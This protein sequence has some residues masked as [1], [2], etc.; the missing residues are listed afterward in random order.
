MDRLELTITI[1]TIILIS[2]IIF[3]FSYYFIGKQQVDRLN[4][5]PIYRDIRFI[6]PCFTYTI[7]LGYRYNYAYDWYQYQQTFIYLLTGRLYREDTEI[8]YLAINWIL[9]QLGFSYYS[10]FILEGFIWIFAICFIC[11]E[12]RKAWIFILPLMYIV[13]KF[14]CLNISRQFFSMSIFLI[15]FKHLL[16]GHNIKY[17]ILGG[18]AFLIHSA[19]IIYV[20]PLY[21]I[22]KFIKYPPII[23]TLSIYAILFI[24]QNQ[25]QDFLFHQVEFITTNIITNKGDDYYTYDNL[26]DKF[27]WEQRSIIR[28]LFQASK[29]ILYI[30]FIYKLKDTNILSQQQKTIFYIGFISIFA[31]TAMGENEISTRLIIY[32]TMFYYI[33]WGLIYYYALSYPQR[34]VPI[35]YKLIS[36][37]IL[38][39]YIYSFYESIITEVN[40]G[41]YLEYRI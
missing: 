2:F 30:F 24:F 1:F 28:R 13:F 34:L 19:A 39:H 10:I 25:I 5:T 3:P 26:T 7:L 17:W 21:F 27:A 8:G 37:F 32:I 4:Q 6:I 33:G 31:A 12:Y 9:G 35:W 22:K 14:R 40:L 15:A 20:V 11:K 38:C 18:V 29:D 16:N 36:I 23:V 41:V